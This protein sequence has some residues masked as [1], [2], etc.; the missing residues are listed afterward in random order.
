MIR[1][2]KCCVSSLF[3]SYQDDFAK[4]L[5][6]ERRVRIKKPLAAV[7]IVMVVTILTLILMMMMTMVTAIVRVR[8][9]VIMV[10]VV[11]STTWHP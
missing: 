3:F 11:V 4:W 6:I 7:A 5:R 1:H 2:Q 10:V 9:I 8:I